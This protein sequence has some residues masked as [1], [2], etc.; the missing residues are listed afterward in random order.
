MYRLNEVVL[1]LL[2][3]LLA[4]RFY[5]FASLLPLLFNLF[6]K[7]RIVDSHRIVIQFFVDS[8]LFLSD[9]RVKTSFK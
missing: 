3:V 1:L 4:L 5:F 9:L 7:V 8:I 2:H 6:E